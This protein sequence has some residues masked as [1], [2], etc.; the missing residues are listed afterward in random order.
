M[1]HMCP[2]RQ[3]LSLY[4]DGELP[5]PW[6]EKLEGHLASCPGCRALVESW[7]RI[8]RELRIEVDPARGERVWE[9]VSARAAAGEV[10]SRESF[11]APRGFSLSELW[12]RRVSLPLPAAA[13]LGVAAAAFV[14]VFGSMGRDSPPQNPVPASGLPFVSMETGGLDME[15]KDIPSVGDSTG[16][17]RYLGTTDASDMVIHLPESRSFRSAG[18]PKLIRAADYS[19][20]RAQE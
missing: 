20:G 5:S 7:G 9:A 15:F 4:L 14:F 13:A 12:R 1:V 10:P 2:D 11:P 3:I 19:P 6:K 17:S 18:E 8:S 16:M